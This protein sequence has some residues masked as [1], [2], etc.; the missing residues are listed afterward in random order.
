MHTGFSYETLK[1]RNHLEGLGT[2]GSIIFKQILKQQ[3][4]TESD[5]LIWL[6]MWT[7]SGPCEHGNEPSGYT[8]CGEFD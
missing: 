6:R 7:S 5:G 1:E 3:G 2:D 8:E 4:G